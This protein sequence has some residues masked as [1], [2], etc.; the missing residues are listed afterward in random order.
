MRLQLL[1]LLDE[2]MGGAGL[3]THAQPNAR[4]PARLCCCVPGLRAQDVSR[5]QARLRAAERQSAQLREWLESA[6][7][8]HVAADPAWRAGG[9]LSVSRLEGQPGMLQTEVLHALGASKGLSLAYNTL[10]RLQVREAVASA[11]H[12]RFGDQRPPPL[13][14]DRRSCAAAARSGA[15]T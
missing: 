2:L 15:S 6:S 14:G 13:F 11:H 9:A 5:L 3:A 8:A 7:A 12:C 4:P 1:P 10:E